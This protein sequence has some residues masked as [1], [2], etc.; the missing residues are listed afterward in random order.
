L[1]GVRGGGGGGGAVRCRGA[2]LYVCMLVRLPACTEL[3]PDPPHC[4]LHSAV[5]YSAVHSAECSAEWRV[6]S[7]GGMESAAPDCGGGAPQTASPLWSHCTALHCT[8]LHCTAL[9]PTAPHCTAL[10]H[11]SPQL[12]APLNI[13]VSSGARTG[14]AM[15]PV[16]GLLTALKCSYEISRL[17]PRVTSRH[18]A[19]VSTRP[20]KADGP[21]RAGCRRRMWAGRGRGSRSRAAGRRGSRR[22]GSRSLGSLL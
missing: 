21:G 4:T 15:Q 10:H 6:Q 5:Q 13:A 22:R 16:T 1:G 8:A 12:P 2:E 7:M 11:R 14:P 18:Q 19:G 3:A 17:L 9:H 20:S